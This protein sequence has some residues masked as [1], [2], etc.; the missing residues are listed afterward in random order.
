MS[1]RCTEWWGTVF[2]KDIADIGKDI[3]DIF[4]H[5]PSGRFLV[6]ILHGFW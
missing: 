4:I 6:K 3:A 1:A 2:G 5:V